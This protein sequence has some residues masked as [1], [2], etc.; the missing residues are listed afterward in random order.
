MPDGGGRVKPEPRIWRLS[1]DPYSPGTEGLRALSGPCER[2]L[3]LDEDRDQACFSAR[4]EVQ[5][6][7][8]AMIEGQGVSWWQCVNWNPL[9]DGGLF[10][11]LSDLLKWSDNEVEGDILPIF[12][13]SIWP[14]VDPKQGY[15]APVPAGLFPQLAQ[16]A[17]AERLVSIQEPSGKPKLPTFE[18]MRGTPRQEER[19]VLLDYGMD[20]DVTKGGRRPVLENAI[21]QLTSLLLVRVPVRG[22]MSPALPV[23]VAVTVIASR[24]GGLGC[25]SLYSGDWP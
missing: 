12:M 23:S 5:A 13:R 14:G 21:D 17:L 20:D 1:S 2:M 10:I 8:L 6:Y 18:E 9:D 7:R 15:D 16:Y 19:P 25:P 24:Y 11:W 3:D 4:L 22:R